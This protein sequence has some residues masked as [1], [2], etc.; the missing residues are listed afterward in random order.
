MI[1]RATFLAASLSF[2]SCFSFA[3]TGVLMQR[4]LPGDSSISRLGEEGSLSG[5]VYSIVGG[6]PMG[7]VRVDLRQVTNGSTIGS[8]YTS[9]SG[10][11]EFQ[12]VPHGVYQVVAVS[13]ISQAE[14]RVEINSWRASVNLRMPPSQ[15]P[16][17][18]G[19]ADTVSV[20]Q[21]KVPKKAR[22]EF[23]KAQQALA[24][25]KLEEAQKRVARALEIY[26]DFADALTLRAILQLS[27]NVPGAIADLQKAIHC[28]GNYALAYSVLGA[29]LNSQARFDE[30]LQTLARGQSLAPEAWQ[31]Y[32]EMAKA[33]IGKQDYQTAL[34]ELDRAQSLTP[35]RYL[36]LRLVRAQALVSLKQYPQAVAELQAYV[37]KEPDGPGAVAAHKM[38]DQLREVMA[39][40]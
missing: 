37:E 1:M 32:F 10:V 35:G 13:G 21:F 40:R 39:K 4:Q 5:T 28:D 24:K 11:F 7:N 36:P 33:H 15:G 18:G 30:A 9:S 27:G 23:Q 26:P 6:R 8:A 20:A 14:E 2:F 12:S 3:Q 25:Q 34:R 31:T 38:L 29:A 19:D 16:P 22:E 17:Q